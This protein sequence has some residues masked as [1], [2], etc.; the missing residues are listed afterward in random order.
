M[1]SLLGTLERIVFTNEE[2]GYIIARFSIPRRY[3]LVTVVGNLAGVHAGA[4]LRLWGVWKNHSVYGEQFVIENYKEERPATI[5]AIRKYLGSGLIKGIGP[6]TATR[7]AEHFGK[8][9]LDVIDEDIG[10]L[11]EVP[12]VGPKRVG[13]IAEAWEAQKSIKEIMLFLQGHGVNTRLAVKIYK[14]YAD[15]AI[16][17]VEQD[18]YRLARDIYGI[19]FITADKIARSLGV[20]PDSPTRIQAGLEHLL[21]TLADEG[22]VYAPRPHAVAETAKLLDVSTA[23]V[24]AQIAVL[25]NEERVQLE[26]LQSSATKTEAEADAEAVYLIPFYRAEVGVARQI[27]QLQMTGSTQSALADFQRVDWSKAFAY[28]KQK[29]GLELAEGQVEAV[30]MA[31]TEP[32]SILTGG[33]GTGKTTT[34]RTILRLLKAKSGQVLLAAPTGRA[35]KRLTETTGHEAKTLHR[36]LEVDPGA[37]FRFKRNRDNPL[38][39]DMIIIDEV[40][41]IDLILM[42][43]LLKAI[44]PGTHL[45]LVGDADQLPS[46]GAG[47]VLR[48]MIASE[49]LPT[50]RLAVIFRQAQDSTIIQNAHRINNGEPLFFPKDKTDFYFFGKADPDEVAQLIVDI[51][52]NRI[53]K[54]FGAD[55]RRDIQLLSPM[56][57]GSVGVGNLNQLLQAKLNPPESDTAQYQAGSRLYRAG[58]KVL[59]LRNNYDRDVFNGDVGVIE[60]IDLEESVASIRFEERL[61]NYDLSELDEVTLAYAI[62][63]HKSQGSEYPIVVMPVL[64]Q[65]YLLLQRNLLYTG[66][67]RAKKMVVLVGTRKAIAIAVKNNR[68]DQRWSGLTQRLKAG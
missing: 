19:G 11:V 9:T 50:V 35:A 6:V 24:D 53:P 14:T 33:P 1:E 62:S 59:Q 43:N 3:D 27:R 68:I 66:V 37:G 25:A 5:E 49:V 39:A 7:I 47:N 57:R 31:L 56:H 63:V 10:R 42:N 22:H 44:R 38:Q 55:P 61:V 45:L 67:T 18:P 65:H 58:D 36:L 52:V 2:N 46:V 4:R 28:V 34:V 20:E 41:M 13:I 12:G 17:V 51:V 29:D 30:K 21:K 8:Y 16:Q 54:K 32:V 40:S 23:Q 64:T 60:K 15:E 48:D 26:V